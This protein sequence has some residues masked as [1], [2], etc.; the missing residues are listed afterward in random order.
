MLRLPKQ[1]NKVVPAIKEKWPGRD[2]NITILQQDIVPA[3]IDEDDAAFIAFVTFKSRQLLDF[4]FLMLLQ[5]CIDN[6]LGIQQGD[7]NYWI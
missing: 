5:H 1:G 7:N 6:I 3:H 4:A 2:R